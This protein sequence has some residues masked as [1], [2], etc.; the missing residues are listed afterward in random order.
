MT[1]KLKIQ[2]AILD[3][4]QEKLAEIIGV[5]RQTVNAIENNKYVPSTV[6]TLKLAKTFNVNVEEI[7]ELTDDDL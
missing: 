6:I 7:F 4:T 5:S 3:V 2:R 1:N